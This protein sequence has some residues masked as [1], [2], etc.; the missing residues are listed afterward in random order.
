[1]KSRISTGI[2]ASVAMLALVAACGGGGEKK[3]AAPK[4][5]APK[6]EAPAT[7]EAPKTAEA[8]KTDPAAP[9]TPAAGAIQLAIKDAA[10]AAV[11]GDPGNGAKVFRQ[12]QTCHVVVAGQNKVG[13]S[14]HAI[15]GRTAG[16]VPG[17]RYSEANKNSGKVWTEQ[18]L[19]DYLENPRAT[20]PGTIMAFAGLKKPQDRADVV[21]YLKTATN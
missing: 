2:I 1:M 17:F 10:G 15:I 7:P 12:C 9:A 4:A 14:L 19:Y 13:P 20:I 3:D 21:A 11:S 6:V 18:A 16:Q 8:P 5:E